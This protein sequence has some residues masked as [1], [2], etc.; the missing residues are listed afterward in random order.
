MIY[1]L[2][3][4][5]IFARK[6]IEAHNAEIVSLAYSPRL[7][8]EESKN[9][10]WLASGSRDSLVQLYDKENE[11]EAVGVLQTH[12]QTVTGVQ[13]N[14]FTTIQK[15]TKFCKK[16]NLAFISCSVDKSVVSQQV[17]LEKVR[18]AK[19]F[20]DLQLNAESLFENEQTKKCLSDPVSIAVAEKANFMVLGHKK[21][22]TFWQVPSLE[23]VWFKKISEKKRAGSEN[24]ATERNTG[25]KTN[26]EE[27]VA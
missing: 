11:Y 10:F 25:T 13:F 7:S 15:K 14:S 1:D 18:S 22:L 17:K 19:D 12:D 24:Y 16:E 4:N 26:E 21:M 3:Q 9:Q 8:E 27:S 5:E 20:E 6:T 23:R 2:T